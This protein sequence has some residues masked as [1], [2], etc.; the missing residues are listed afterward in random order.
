[1]GNSIAHKMSVK[2]E[3]GESE[4]QTKI[5]KCVKNDIKRSDKFKKHYQYC[6]CAKCQKVIPIVEDD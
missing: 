1:M 3:E 4:K 5:V 6:K 2:N